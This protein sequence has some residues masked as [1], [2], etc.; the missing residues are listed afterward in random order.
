MVS[1]LLLSRASSFCSL[2]PPS[3]HSC[4]CTPVGHIPGSVGALDRC[5]FEILRET[6]QLPAVS[7]H[8]SFPGKGRPVRPVGQPQA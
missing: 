1:R 5:V 2:G 4:L 3:F 6:V 8:C 7:S